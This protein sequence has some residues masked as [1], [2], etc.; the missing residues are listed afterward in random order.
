MKLRVISGLV[1][2]SAI[3][4]AGWKMPLSPAAPAAFQGV[5]RVEPAY[6]A[7]AT[8][9]ADLSERL[10][11]L[12]QEVNKRH[13]SYLIDEWRAVR[14][15]WQPEQT[16]EQIALSYNPGL[17]KEEVGE[18]VDSMLSA[19]ERH[20]VDPLLVAAVIAHESRFRP[21]IVSPGGAVGLGQLM[22][23]TAARLGVDPYSPAQNIEGATKYLGSHLKRWSG[24][25]APEE[26]ALASYNAGPGAVEQWGGVP[27]YSATR[28]YVE[29]I[30]S[31][32]KRFQG[33]A[34]DDKSRWLKA[35]GPPMRDLFGRKISAQHPKA[36]PV[37]PARLSLHAP[38]N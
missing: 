25:G 34:E 32:Y 4:V 20:E 28:H 16:L 3:T 1:L 27:P 10:V 13:V 15:R 30:S 23:S 19:A 12:E 38:S 14:K 36:E 7:T 8:V 5:P 21:R 22:P 17:S 11:L 26:L 37:R 24:T 29:S 6:Q 31:R 9:A 35:N 18:I 2:L 33:Q